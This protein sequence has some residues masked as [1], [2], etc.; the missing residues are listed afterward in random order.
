MI[1]KK[2]PAK[3]VGAYLVLLGTLALGLAELSAVQN[4]I[5]SKLS[6]TSD[7]SFLDPAMLLA[8]GVPIVVVTVWQFFRRKQHWAQIW[9]L[10][11]VPLGVIIS[12]LNLVSLLQNADS[13]EDYGQTI[14]KSLLAIGYGGLVS[15]VGYQSS[16]KI[17][18][19]RLSA[20]KPFAARDLWL[21]PMTLVVP[22]IYANSLTSFGAVFYAPAIL[23]FTG[24]LIFPLLL[25]SKVL[26][27]RVQILSESSIMASLGCV[28][29]AL[30]VYYDGDGVPLLL[31]P[32]IA[33]GLL[34]LIYGATTIF[35]LAIL[36]GPEQLKL[37]NF[38][39]RIW[40]LLEIYGL[41]VL[42]CFAPMALQE[43]FG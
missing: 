11:G 17:V 2:K 37:S 22:I 18:G 4:E 5:K 26:V 34:G 23:I 9:Y 30:I 33:V 6:I 19:D 38:P 13:P 15:V 21:I 1:D 27:S 40:H 39:L 41:W 24:L 31:G 14:A 8:I 7:F 20:P 35:V 32:P 29:C 16:I 12:A 10:C 25:N 3:A 28:L 43:A 36:A 42:M